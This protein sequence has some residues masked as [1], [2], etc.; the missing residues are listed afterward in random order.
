[1]NFEEACQSIL[2]PLTRNQATRHLWLGDTGMGKT[3]ANR[4]LI[5]YIV[6]HQLAA[7]ILTH[8]EKDPF[9]PQYP[10]STM[11]INPQDLK[12]NPPTEKES[13]QHISF[14]GTAISMQFSESVR[15]DEIAVMAWDVVRRSRCQV[16]LNIDELS[17][18]LIPNSQI[19]DGSA[20]GAAYRKGRSVG[21]SVIAGIQQPQLLPREAFGLAE[22]IGLFRMDGREAEYLR[23]NKAITDEVA[24]RLPS[25]SVGQFILTKKGERDVSN[26][27]VEVPYNGERKNDEEDTTDSEGSDQSDVLQ[28]EGSGPATNGRDRRFQPVILRGKRS[29]VSTSGGSEGSSES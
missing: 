22:T 26:E 11:R 4:A 15:P 1:M 8:D 27:T 24:S 25:L 2:A 21:I 18:A 28:S 17:D 19:W 16:V 6:Q 3:T 23:R 13:K 7:L 9:D 20:I 14:R 12:A 10:D 5:G 29:E